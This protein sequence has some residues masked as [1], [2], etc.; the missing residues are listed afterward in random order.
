MITITNNIGNKVS[1]KIHLTEGSNENLTPKELEQ[2]FKK[3][4]KI[5]G[6]GKDYC[7]C[8]KCDLK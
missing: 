1:Y 8:C 5:L 2:L 3:V 7:V 6:K 4:G